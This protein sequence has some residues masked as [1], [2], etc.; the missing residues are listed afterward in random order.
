MQSWWPKLSFYWLIFIAYNNNLDATQLILGYIVGIREIIYIGLTLFCLKRNPAF[1]L[2]DV[3]GTF[4]G[5]STIS[6]VFS[7]V[8]L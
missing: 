3:V 4:N 8:S 1:L 2:V 5:Y 6:C 7:Q